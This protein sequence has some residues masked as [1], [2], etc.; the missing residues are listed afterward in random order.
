MHA[1]L[2]G[3][4]AERAIKYSIG[5][6]FVFKAKQDG[7]IIEI[8]TKNHLIFIEYADGSK[9][10]IDTSAKNGRV[11]DG[12]YITV[13]LELD[14]RFKVG[15][16]FKKDDIIA[17]DKSYFSGNGNDA[18]LSMGTLTNVVVGSYDVSYEDSSIIS[19][20]LM[21]DLGTYVTFD[22]KAAISY[23]ANISDVKKMGDNI[24]AGESLINYEEVL[25]TDD[26]SV[27]RLLTK[28]GDRFQ[29]AINEYASS[30]I[31]SKYSGEIVDMRIYFN[32]D[33]EEFSPSLQKLIKSYQTVNQAKAKKLNNTRR[34]HIV[35]IPTIEKV[36]TDR[37][38]GQEFD[39][40]LI[41]YYIRSL[42][43]FIPGNK[44]AVGV[45]LKSIIGAIWNPGENPITSLE[46]P[47]KASHSEVG[48]FISPFST[49]SRMVPDVY[50]QGYTNKALIGLKNNIKNIINEA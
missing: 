50:L 25:G 35:Y 30:S 38:A 21:G 14:P 31:P 18:V 13:H 29:E 43:P 7:K 39:G 40:I 44:L 33:I 28:I 15:S 12:Y 32:R 34:D 5:D 24:R 46:N 17:N 41:H 27:S 48:L 36:N 2:I 26:D 8:D 11:A 16:K 10:A 9:A 19:Y 20:E 1:P 49:A 45:A 6:E 3:C 4:H 47:N 37:I 22:K 42:N 23:S